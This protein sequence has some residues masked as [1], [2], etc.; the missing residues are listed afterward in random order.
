MQSI[1]Q[2]QEFT[3]KDIEVM[4]KKHIENLLKYTD[5]ERYDYF[6]RY[7][8]DL[9]E[10]WALCVD[11]DSWII[12]KDQESDEIFPIW[13]HKDLAIECMFIEH[14][15]MGAYPVSISID[16]FMEECIPDMKNENVYFGVFYDKS[17]SAICVKPE[18]LEKDLL[19]SIEEYE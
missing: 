16:V 17:R 1:K 2:K 11:E 18:K 3:E 14:K 12:F 15:E 10:V 7:C 5:N 4:N 13:P 8:A 9:E 19:S 6:L